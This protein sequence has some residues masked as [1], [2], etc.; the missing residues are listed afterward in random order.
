MADQQTKDEEFSA[1]IPWDLFSEH[2]NATFDTI[3][4]SVE[5]HEQFIQSLSETFEEY[6]YPDVPSPDGEQYSRHL[7]GYAKAYET[8]LEAA[9]EMIGHADKLTEKEE[10]DVESV[11]EFRDIWLSAAN[12]AYKDIM[13][14]TAFSAINAHGLKNVLDLKS[15]ANELA[16][17]TVHELGFASSQDLDEVARRLIELERRQQKV[18]D[19]L[20]RILEQLE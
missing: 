17:D 9:Q 11:K 14:T 8:W 19:K 15:Q 4:Q 7:E 20:D 1:D 16:S 3:H 12:Q 5:A 10:L 13:S 6:E 2:L 18:E